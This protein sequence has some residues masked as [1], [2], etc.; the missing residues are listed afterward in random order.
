[1]RPSRS[2]S[3]A[4]IF[5]IFCFAILAMSSAF[6]QLPLPD[7]IGFKLQGCR[8]YAGITLPDTFTPPEIICHPDDPGK[9]DDAYTDG[10]QGKGWA[11]LGLVPF[12]LTT[13]SGAQ[14]TT[15]DY[16]ITIAADY[17]DNSGTHPLGFDIISAVQKDPESLTPSDGSCSV[18][19]STQIGPPPITNTAAGGIGPG[20]TGGSL[21][22]IYEIVTLHQAAGSTCY[23]AWWQRLAIGSHLYSGSSLQSYLFQGVFQGGKETVPLP[24]VQCNNQPNCA[25]SPAPQS[26]SKDMTATAQGPGNTWSL[27]GS[28][29]GPVTANTCDPNQLTQ[30][31]LKFTI[32]WSAVAS[33]EGT[34]VDIVTHVYAT[35]PSP[36]LVYAQ[37]SDVITGND[38]FNPAAIVTGGTG[39][40]GIPIPANSTN[41]L[42]A[43]D[44]ISDSGG[45]VSDTYSDTATATYWDVFGNPGGSAQASAGPITPSPGNTTNTSA[46]INNLE[47]ITGTDIKFST[48]SEN[49]ADPT[50]GNFDGGYTEGTQ[51]PPGTISWTSTSQDASAVELS[52][53]VSITLSKSIYLPSATATTETLTDSASLTTSDGTVVN[54]S[55]GSLSVLASAAPTVSLTITKNIDKAVATDQTFTFHICK[56]VDYTTAGNVCDNTNELVTPPTIKITAGTLTNN[57]DPIGLQPDIY[58][59]TEDPLAGWTTDKAQ[60]V[61]DAPNADTGAVNC[62]PSVTFTN[63]LSGADLSASKTAVPTLTR[64]YTWTIQKS[65]DQTKIEQVGGTATFNYTVNVTHN[66]GT[67]SA[68]QVAGVITV[69]NPNSFTFTGVNISDSVDNGGTCNVTG[70]SAANIVNGDNTFSY[71]CSYPVTG[72]T[73]LTGTNTV[74]VDWSGNSFP[75]PN[76]SA[77]GQAGFTFADGSSGNPT[78]V[79]GTSTITDNFNGTTTTLGI[80]NA[81]TDTDSSTPTGVTA[82]KVSTG[83]WKFTYSH[84][85]NVPASGCTSYTN[86]ATVVLTTNPPANPFSTVTVQVCGSGKTGALTMGF[87]QNKNGQGIITNYC[88]GTSGM[89][90]YTFLTSYNPFKD[91]TSSTCSKITTYVYNVIKAANASGASMN[92]MLKAQMLSTALDVYFSD[93]TLGGDKI[94]AFNLGVTIPIGGVKIDLTKVCNMIDSSSTLTAT[95]SGTPKYLTTAGT[96]FGA[97]PASTCE[98]VSYLLTYAA[99]QAAQATSTNTLASP[100]YAQ[101]KT[102]QGLAKNTFD[103]INNQAAFT[104]P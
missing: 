27:S 2:S 45:T 84:T 3:F 55:P 65:V 100:W 72:P 46:T 31:K 62:A 57:S 40:M 20:L 63:T 19:S 99:S 103:A 8:F 42:I 58:T 22:S 15:P 82:T 85:V 37:V 49:P 25:P 9:P 96:A 32:T 18:S 23:W 11:E 90:L 26:I 97:P 67:D 50:L 74:T 24:V 87:W 78:V 38:G 69:H 81:V 47:S 80:I 36:S 5:L 29:P 52:G 28:G 79:N 51:V 4:K 59:V 12:R 35:N 66:A 73:K 60:P 89:S 94:A 41:L 71:S 53:P 95:C 86:T 1:M 48:D 77:T 75:T 83:V 93:P 44:T 92:A 16:Q 70:G 88:G 10:N 56:T 64:T 33:G 98:S 21:S 54:M 101:V 91:L 61:N 76:S 13:T 30:S 17:Q 6:A 68:W 43:T 34:G 102:T 104:C 7:H 14:S 39:V